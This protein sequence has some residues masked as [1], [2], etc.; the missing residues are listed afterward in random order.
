M[1]VPKSQC[2]KESGGVGQTVRHYIVSKG[3]LKDAV[4]RLDLF[5]GQRDGPRQTKI[6]KSQKS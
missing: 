4:A 5:F 6:Q 1:T 2:R 3:D